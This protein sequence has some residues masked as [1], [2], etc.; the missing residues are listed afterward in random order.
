LMEVRVDPCQSARAAR[1]RC[2]GQFVGESH[3][4]RGMTMRLQQR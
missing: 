1:K 3:L 2:S 4:G